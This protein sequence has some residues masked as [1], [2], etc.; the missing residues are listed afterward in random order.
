MNTKIKILIVALWIVWL[1]T[2]IVTAKTETLPKVQVANS[3]VTFSQ[4]PVIYGETIQVVVWAWH[5]NQNGTVTVNGQI[6]NVS[7]QAVHSVQIR[8]AAVDQNTQIL[9]GT[10]VESNIT[11]MAPG[12]MLPFATTFST[13]G[14]TVD[15]V[16]LYS[17]LWN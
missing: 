1:I 17:I 2:I 3:T 4:T 12:Q 5:L 15:T 14:N 10:L 13:A 7:D 11:S 9:N 16:A 8:I 6:K